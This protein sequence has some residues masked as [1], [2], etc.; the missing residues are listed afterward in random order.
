VA[1][2]EADRHSMLHLYRDA[3]ALRPALGRDLVFVPAAP[4]VLAYRRGEYLVAVSFAGEAQPFPAVGDVVV[5]ATADA[6]KDGLLAP[7][8]AVVLR[9]PQ[10]SAA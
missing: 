3:I 9:A 5:A 6:V 2:Q 7:G 4:G 10:A 8:A 1:E